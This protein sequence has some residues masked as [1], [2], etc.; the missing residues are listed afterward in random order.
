M[1]TL[2]MDHL[3]KIIES[4]QLDPE[5]VREKMEGIH[6]KISKDLSITFYHL[7]QNYLWFSPHPEDPIETR[8]GLRK[9][10]LIFSK[11]RHT[12]TSI[13]FIEK[14]YR[15]RDPRYADFSIRQQMEIL[16]RLQTEW[17]K[18]ECIEPPAPHK[19]EKK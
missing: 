10:D 17:N 14:N 8:W 2:L 4:N 6:L 18:T 16:W 12:K 19:S 5:R 11:I 15:R 9:C 1:V 13:A 3:H 7:Y